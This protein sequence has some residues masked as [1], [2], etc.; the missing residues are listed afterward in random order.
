MYLIS[1]TVLV[2]LGIQVYRNVQ[3]YQLNKQRLINDVQLA[4]DTSVEAYYADIAK[5]EM[6]SFSNLFNAT[7]SLNIGSFSGNSA[8]VNVDSSGVS[9]GISNHIA[10]PLNSGG[11]TFLVGN[12]N[13]KISD[14]IR[15]LPINKL[16]DRN[17]FNFGGLDTLANFRNFTNQ[18]VFSMTRDSID[19]ERLE[20]FVN[21]ELARNNLSI[22]YDLIHY[23]HD[24][25]T[26]HLNELKASSGYDLSAN[27]KSTFL[28]RDERLEMKFENASL[29]ILKR[30]RTDFLIS[31]LISVS[32][33]GSLL[34]LYRIIN[35]QK[36]LA[37][38]KNDLISNITHE[39]KTPIATI[40]T[41]IDGIMNFNEKKDQ[42]KTEKYLEI[43]SSQLTKLNHMVEKLL[44][45]ATLDSD[46]LL[47]T[48]E[49]VDVIKMLDNLTEKYQ[50]IA[51]NKQVSFHNDFPTKLVQADL[52]HLENAIS[53][54][55]D[56]AVKYGG[57]NID[58]TLSQRNEKLEIKVE[59][60]GHAIDKKQKE[61]IFEK[62]YRVSTGNRHDVKG[63]GI[64]LYYA[65]KII[66]KHG[67]TIFLNLDSKKTSF[68]VAI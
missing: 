36:A 7:D 46:K 25:I 38:V 26:G 30:G 52:F 37:E 6:I 11:A 44:E 55:I 63:F 1:F 56:N 22:P 27:T 59:D 24:A 62:F 66:E 35:Q 47:L 41:A 40:A 61:L 23:R 39:F 33:I 42:K 10:S 21:D 12:G 67:G 34:Y 43:S 48:I 64:G 51:K 65:K 60:D 15:R 31:L 20:K 16:V 68:E 17:I 28:P 5:T 2:T 18:I 54:L 8:W 50:L 4:L 53:N 49:E 45:T 9:A 29:I 13:V 57:N 32:V 14:T 58:I 3:N 19:F